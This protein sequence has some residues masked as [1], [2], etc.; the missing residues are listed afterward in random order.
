MTARKRGRPASAEYLS[1]R[2]AAEAMTAAGLPVSARTVARWIDDGRLPGI[3]PG[4]R[5]GS[6]RR[7]LRTTVEDFLL[8]NIDKSDE[9]L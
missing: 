1:P 9:A 5:A 2:Q 4:S 3:R 6:H 8:K 7:V